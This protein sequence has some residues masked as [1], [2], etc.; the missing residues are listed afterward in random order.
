DSVVLRWTIV[1]GNC[2]DTYDEMSIVNFADAVKANAGIDQ[3]ACAQATPFTLDGNTATP[4]TA[5]G[6]WTV[7]YGAANFG[8]SSINDPKAQVTVPVGDSVVLRWTITN[9]VCADTYDE[10]SIVNYAEAVK[11]N[12]GIDQKACAQTTPF[13]LDGNTATPATAIGRW[14]VV[15]GAANF[16]TSSIND[17]KA[18]VTVAVGDSV[19]LR[20]TITNGVC[21]DSY[22][23]MS[24][25]NFAEAVKANAGADQ[26]ACAQT[27][28]F[29][30]DGNTATPA[31]AIGRWTVVYGAANFGTSSINDPK[32]QVTVAVGDSVVLRWT[33]TN[34]VCADTYDEM[35]I[36]NFAEAVKANA[37]IDQK[38]CAQTTP[39]TLDGNTATP[40]TA[41]GRWTVVYGAANFGTSSIN[42]PKAQVTV[43][44]GDSV[45][46][47]WT[48]TNGVCADTYDEMSIVNFADAVKANAGIDQK[49]CAQTTP[50]TL[51]GNTASPA[52]A[53]GRWT[54]VYGAANFGTSSI[55][56]P[57]AQVTVAVG[58]SVVLRWTIVNGNCADTYDEMSIVNFAEAV[59]ANAGIDQKACAQ[60]TPFTLDG[61]TATPATAIG[62]WTVV[63]GTAN[64][65]TSSINDPKAQVTVAVG[66]SV[67]LRW[68]IVNGNCADTYDEMSIVNFADAV[69]ANAGIDQKACA[70]ATPFTL[71]GNTATPATAIGRWTVVYGAANFGTSSINDPKAQVT[72]AVG[73]SVVLR[74]TIVNG[75]C[76]DSYDEMSIVNFAEAVKAN[77]GID[78]KACAQATPFTLDGNT[79]T[80]AT[81]IGR[82]T[83]VYGAA[84][85]GTSSINDPKAQVTVAVGDSVV[86]RWTITNGVCADTYDEMSIVNFADAV[87]A[88]A[89]IDQKA[90]AQT[91]PFTL[92]GNTATPATAIGRWTVVYGAANFGTSSI[93]DPK[94][95]VTV[96]V[97]DS[98]VL[99]WTITNGVCAD[100]Y[101]E[102]S[103]VNF[104][105]AVK[106][107]AGADQKACAQTTAFTLDGN[108]ATPATAIGR[109]T[110]VYG[111]A[112]F[113]TS[114]INDPKAQVTV[115]VGDSVVLRWTI[116]NGNCADTYDEMSIV[117]YAEAVKANAGINQKACAQTTAFTLDG[118]TA[119]P[120]TAIG[121]WTVVYGAANFGTS[122][123][124]DPKAQVTVAVGDSVVLR[125]TIVNGN[126]ADTY[127]EMSIV[128]FA[129][130]VKANAG[131]DQ[132][133][134]AQ[135]TPFTLDGNT[136]TPATA[137]GRWTVVYGAANFGTSSINDPKAQVTVAVG[138]SVVLR[139]TIVNGNC[140]DTY[141][142]MS[143]VNFAEAVKANAGADQKACAQATPFTLDGNTATP[144]TAIGRWTV[145]YGAANFGTS[146]INDPKAQVT[147]AVGD[148]VVLRWTIVNGN[149]ADTYDEMS[150]VNFADAVKA[151]AGI[152]Q[153][154]CAQTTPF[155][156]DGNTATPATAIGRW[157]VVY[158][159][160]NFGTSSINDPKAQVTVAV[161]DSVVLR[162]TIVNGNCAD[163]YD[164]MSIVNY[165][166]AVKANAGIDQKACA[167][168][169]PFTLDGNTATP[170]TAIG[171]WTVVYGA[172][173][174]GT[175]SINDPK[176]QVTVAVGDSV[177]L[178]WTITNGVCADTYDEMSIVN[179]ADAV[180]A[181][182]GIDQ[183]AC[184]QTTPFT[185]DGNTAT[186]ATAI[187]RWTVVYGN[188][189]FGTSSINDPKAQVT[190]AVGDSV[191]LRWTI[192]NG[193]CADSY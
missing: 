62:R 120:A 63:Y 132:K 71:D 103:I 99:R 114:S 46:L 91:T 69:K 155:T 67:V 47:R 177:V 152:D 52:T 110:V 70:Q 31:T 42:D 143:I 187:G 75:N 7:V 170:A 25:V 22:D 48:V 10:M 92:D 30:L 14:T 178:R 129:E 40:A 39:F 11:A 175:S 135:A 160:A 76:A 45:V 191:V 44:V 162:W 73:D 87:K 84:N 156:V 141:D 186:P 20:W 23:E 101:D 151:N 90:C 113:G 61:N 5:I 28:A 163:S 117:N 65:G 137:I 102:M 55:N 18:Q 104:A 49:A 190:V 59:K 15:Y 3:K 115:A 72:V 100:S 182:A 112:N 68:T 74:W 58:D 165:A 111:A 24:I 173:N 130:A 27:T 6:R 153:K 29:T 66:D 105:E 93:N 184:A 4:A 32:A 180:K 85:F 95:Q 188:A 56:D 12:A 116:V 98:V 189:N 33:I 183:K 145:V 41:I 126:C 60:A 43:A 168:T 149:C 19:V 2:A 8:T 82:W 166:E 64:F 161:G 176:A 125:W 26:K 107:N 13:T 164:E 80:P 134:C 124:N 169:T 78:Q 50:F 97:G 81:A 167:Q 109:W 123:I 36:V 158:G 121:R 51:D 159:A 1:N 136:A 96:A 146:S 128:N 144:A 38:A 86:L 193:V 154:A 37:G 157:T 89:G 139:W 122:S 57:K 171:R 131:A 94:A 83:V 133:A 21:A 138:D 118:N 35:S 106:A 79:A 16:G 9:G 108:T 88:N 181:N 172:A 142:E 34:G 185:L 54:V 140:A 174:F 17:P 127:D 147:V 77:A 53:I 148:S 150:I 192:T 119:T 179:F